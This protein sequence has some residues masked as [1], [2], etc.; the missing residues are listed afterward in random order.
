MSS[1]GDVD[2]EVSE[3]QAAARDKRSSTC[4]ALTRQQAVDGLLELQQRPE[5]AAVPS[6]G[7]VR[8]VD[9]EHV[10]LRRPQDCGTNSRCDTQRSTLYITDTLEHFLLDVLK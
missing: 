3:E 2:V 10:T 9:G 6:D 8:G 1:P 7:A 4:E 5:D